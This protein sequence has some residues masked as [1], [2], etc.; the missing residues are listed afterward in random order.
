[1]PFWYSK[2]EKATF[3]LTS[4]SKF[5]TQEKVLFSSYRAVKKKLKIF[6]QHLTTFTS[7]WTMW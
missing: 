3:N 4:K 7:N 5:V 2:S 6:I 1:M